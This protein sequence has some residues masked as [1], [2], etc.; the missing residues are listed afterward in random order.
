MSPIV[1]RAAIRA[2]GRR[3]FSVMRS[4]RNAMRSFEPHPFER[5]PTTQTAQGAD[6]GKMAKRVAG[7]A[8]IYV[9]GV[10][11]VLG[12]PYLAAVGLDGHI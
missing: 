8:V 12:W 10:A 4:V 9:P 6:V 1:A 2:A 5:L 11:L 3:N 7:Q